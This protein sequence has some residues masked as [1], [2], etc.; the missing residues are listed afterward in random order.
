MPRGRGVGFLSDDVNSAAKIV[1][2][3]LY[4]L[5][6][7]QALLAEP[8]IAALLAQSRRLGAPDG[9]SPQERE[10]MLAFCEAHAAVEHVLR[11]ELATTDTM[12]LSGVGGEGGPG[13]NLA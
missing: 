13:S 11:T 1:S 7:Q 12:G 8:R 6:E 2:N 9:I 3:A 4:E 5:H 10:G